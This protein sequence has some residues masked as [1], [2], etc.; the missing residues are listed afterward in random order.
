M[1][2]L[3]AMEAFVRVVD[4][5]SFAEAA[6]RWGR[7]KAVVSKY[8][9]QLEGHLGVRLLHRTTRS[10]SPTEAGRLHLE[11][12]RALLTELDEAEARLHTE[13]TVPKGILRISAPPGLLSRYH[14]SVLADFHAR[15]PDVTLELDLTHRFVDLTEERIDVAIRLTKPDDS[16]LVARWLGPIP[17]V[18][19][20]APAYLA[21]HGTPQQPEDLVHHAAVLDT[22]FRF[23]P[24]WPFRV[25]DR[26]FTVH[27]RGPVRVNSP[28]VVRDLALDGVGIGL[29]PHFLVAPML[30]HDTLVEVLPGTVDTDWS[31]YAVTSQRRHLPSRA[32]VFIDHLR[33]V[34]QAPTPSEKSK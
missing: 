28:I 32:R 13:H 24:R 20:A 8:V 12:S 21:A 22:N 11:A 25:A 17:L 2:R 4:A 27:V 16:A 18:L 34:F 30:D 6:R 7:S 19:V 14:R 29:V 5:G 26:R 33:A 9:A 31:I 23:H 1:D 10:L 3:L 15:Y